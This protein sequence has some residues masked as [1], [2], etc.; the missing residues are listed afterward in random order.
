MGIETLGT[1]LEKIGKREEGLL[2][3]KERGLPENSK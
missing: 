1:C 3:N 2:E